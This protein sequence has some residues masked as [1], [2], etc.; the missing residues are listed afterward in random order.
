VF[1]RGVSVH[2]L[3]RGPAT[4]SD[5]LPVIVRFSVASAESRASP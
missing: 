3:H 2:D 5:H 4:G 1:A